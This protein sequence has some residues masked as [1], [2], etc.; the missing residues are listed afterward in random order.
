MSVIYSQ[1]EHILTSDA[2]VNIV[3]PW[4]GGRIPDY[5]NLYISIPSIDIA[6]PK[7]TE[8]SS[9]PSVLRVTCST[10]GSYSLSR[11]LC[12]FL[13]AKEMDYFNIDHNYITVSGST[14]LSTPMQITNMSQSK[15]LAIDKL[16]IKLVD[17]N[18]T[19]FTQ[20]STQ[21]IVVRIDWTRNYEEAGLDNAE[22]SQRFVAAVYDRLPP[23]PPEL[24][25][26]P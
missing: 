9:L 23:L 17:T 4:S 13:T 24:V 7:S 15:L 19:T 18:N 1:Y 5:M 2:V 26:E 11:A 16:R 21:R 25:E 10:T 6:L 22:E 3:D 20:G 14:D 8:P 12:S